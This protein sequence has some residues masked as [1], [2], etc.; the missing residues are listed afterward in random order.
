MTEAT[1]Q[2]QLRQLRQ[3]RTMEDLTGVCREARR[4]IKRGEIALPDAID[5][6]Y[7]IADASGLCAKLGTE[8]VYGDIQR[9]LTAGAR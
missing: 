6:L 4:L 9:Q 7:E 1:P 2:K 8:F 5:R 3:V